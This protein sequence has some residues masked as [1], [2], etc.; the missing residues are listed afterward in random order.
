[1][2]A[3]PAVYRRIQPQ[4][5]WPVSQENVALDSLLALLPSPDPEMNPASRQSSFSN[6]T[7][8]V[9]RFFFDPNTADVGTLEKLGMASWLANRVIKYRNAG[10]RFRS[11]DDLKKI[12]GF[13]DELFL[14]L[15][16]FI[17]LPV[18]IAEREPDRSDPDSIAATVEESIVGRSNS[19]RYSPPEPFDA[20]LA[21][22]TQWKRVYGI[23]SAYAARIVKFR[24]TLGGFVGKEQLTEVY[25]LSDELITRLDSLVFVTSAF[26]PTQLSVNTLEVEALAKHPYLK[27]RQANAIVAYRNQHGALALEDFSNLRVLTEKEKVRLLPYLSFQEE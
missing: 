23:G 14:E 20:N 21:D 12:Y 16:P 25:G 22:T 6:E 9:E 10:G 2:L 26:V 8:S 4:P 18:E 5:T 19:F 11:K 17:K 1:M 3:S 7:A 13:P 15:K 24:E 27:Y